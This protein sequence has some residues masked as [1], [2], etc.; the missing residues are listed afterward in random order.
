MD[1]LYHFIGD[2]YK[3]TEALFKILKGC[4]NGVFPLSQHFEKIQVHV[5]VG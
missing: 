1:F 4:Y 2:K 3:L 5:Y